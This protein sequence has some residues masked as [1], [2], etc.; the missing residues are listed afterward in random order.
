MVL[1]VILLVFHK[2]KAGNS[3]LEGESQTDIFWEN[4]VLKTVAKLQTQNNNFFFC[5]FAQTGFRYKRWKQWFCYK[6]FSENKK[7]SIEMSLEEIIIV[8]QENCEFDCRGNCFNCISRYFWLI[9]ISTNNSKLILPVS[10]GFLQ[11]NG[12]HLQ[13]WYEKASL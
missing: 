4:R 9:W 5:I 1:F 6:E 10:N 7:F 12:P 2:E 8:V 3:D 11:I 13:F